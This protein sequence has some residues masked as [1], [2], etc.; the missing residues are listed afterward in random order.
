VDPRGV[1]LVVG[2]SLA[3]LRAAEALRD[4]GFTGSLTLIGDGVREPYDRPP[5]SKQVLKGWVPAGNTKLPR[6]REV[7]A[8]WRLGVATDSYGRCGQHCPPPNWTVGGQFIRL[9]T[10]R[11]PLRL[12]PALQ[13][14]I[15]A[16]TMSSYACHD[17]LFLLLGR[18]AVTDVVYKELTPRG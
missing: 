13:V 2:A 6:L 14:A 7:N 10:R 5:V 3:G 4:E 8:D 11:R 15:V 16:V 9:Q 12:F 1:R 17:L 18:S